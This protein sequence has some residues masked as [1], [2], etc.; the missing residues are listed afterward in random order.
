MMINQGDLYW[1]QFKDTGE[2]ESSI[3]H[4]HVVIQ[5][6]LFNRSRLKTVV[7]LALTSNLRRITMPGSVL[8]DAGEGNLAK[9]SVVEVS[10]L[11]SIEKAQLGEYIGSLSKERIRQILAGMQF[12]ERSFFPR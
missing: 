3:P 10:K 1:V 12:L 9:P 8:L 6:D 11:C 2:A 5:D 7:T 4:P